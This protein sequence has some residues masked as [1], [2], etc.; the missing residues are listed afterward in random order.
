MEGDFVD[1]NFCGEDFIVVYI[2]VVNYVID[3][4]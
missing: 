2:E 1:L 4:R 3:E